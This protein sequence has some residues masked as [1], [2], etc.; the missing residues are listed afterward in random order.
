MLLLIRR[1]DDRCLKSFYKRYGRKYTED[2]IAN[3]TQEYVDSFNGNYTFMRVLKY[4][5]IKDV[6]KQGEEVNYV[7]QV[8]E[9]ASYLENAGQEDYN[10]NWTAQLK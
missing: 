8:S 10:K 2:E 7:E 3:A 5:I 6:R 9:L 1:L 4:F